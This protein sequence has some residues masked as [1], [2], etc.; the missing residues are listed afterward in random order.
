MRRLP[1]AN[2]AL[3]MYRN[4]SH[5]FMDGHNQNSIISACVWQYVESDNNDWWELKSNESL[6]LIPF[7]GHG[8][9]AAVGEAVE[10]VMR[11]ANI[12]TTI[13]IR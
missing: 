13:S 8:F 11:D 12:E 6:W 5:V 1:T 7:A 9:D 2:A 3:V 10:Q 4:G